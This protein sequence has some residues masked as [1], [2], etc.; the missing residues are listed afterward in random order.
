M[1]RRTF[2]EAA[3]GLRS[4]ISKAT[5]GN[6][7]R[8]FV[9][10]LVTVVAASTIVG[11]AF[12][13]SNASAVSALKPVATKGSSTA[14][15]PRFT[16]AY[17]IYTPGELYGG[18][19]AVAVCYTCE[20]ANI[21]GTAPPSSSLDAGSGVNALT[22]DYSTTNGLFGSAPSLG[23][24]LSLTY[25]AQ[26]AQ[27]EVAAGG[28]SGEFGVG[29]SSNFDD[30]VT[31]QSG[32]YTTSTVTV[33]QVNGS[34]V[35]FNQ[36]TNGGGCPSGANPSAY[37]YTVS[38]SEDYWC[39]LASV[40]AQLGDWGGTA[41][42]IEYQ[43]NNGQN[44]ES[45]N[46]NGSLASEQTLAPG[47]GLSAA[48]V[49]YNVAPHGMTFEPPCPT[50]AY[51]CT[52][53]GSA[54]E[55]ATT[56]AYIVEALNSSG[57]VTTVYDPSGVTYG[58]TYDTHNNLKSVESYAN[59]TSP[60]TWYYVYT[61]AAASPN[62]S[63]L[64]EIYDPNSGAT[65][66]TG[67]SS[68]AAHSN[69]IVYNTSGSDSGM[70]S[71]VTDGT[72]AT[73]SYSYADPCATGQCVATNAAQQTTVTYPTQVPCPSCTA[74]SPVEVDSYV[75]G[76]E[77]ST[78][79]GSSS[80]A[81]D[82]ETWSYNWSMG[83][84]AA[85]STETITYPNSLAGGTAPTASI[86]LDPEQNVISTTNALGDVATSAYDDVSGDIANQ[87]VWS[88]PGA[89][90][91]GYN[92][93]PAGSWVYTYNGNNEVIR[94]TDPLGNMTSYGYYT[95]DHDPCFV[96]QPTVSMHGKTNSCGAYG[97]YGPPGYAPTGSTAYTYDSFGNVVSTAVDFSDTA[98]GADP[99]TTT[100]SYNV[101]GD[102]L[103]S[104]P[105]AGQSG[106]QSS[107]NPYATVTTYTPSN[108]P[109]T[110][111]PPGHSATTNTY[112]AALN[113]ISSVS[114][115]AT[116]TNAYDADNRQ[117]YQV[118]GGS[119]PGLTC[120]TIS[121]TGTSAVLA[122]STATT[123]VPGSTTAFTSTDGK[124][125]TTVSYY[126]DLAYPSS[127]T[128]VVDAAG[129]QKQYTAYNDFGNAC[130][131]G[132]VSLASQQ[133]T[134]TQC[135]SVA[136]DT[137]TVYNA[138]GDE[139]SI[140]D[141][142]GNTTTNA[143]TNT[144]YP[145][146]ETSS[147]NALSKTTSYAYDADGNETKTTNPDGTFIYTAYDQ[148]NRICTR[149]DGATSDGCGVGTGSTGVTNY[150]YNGASDLTAM[151]AASLS[152]VSK[153]TV[154]GDACSLNSG[155]SGTVDCWGDL[156]NGAIGSSQIPL[157]VAG[158]SGV[159]QVSTG[160]NHTCALLSGG[161]V[162]CWGDN[163]YGELG[164][165]TTTS[166]TTPVTVTGLSNV[167]QVSAGST[168]TCAV[169]T[170]H[171][172]D[173]W[174]DNS[175]Y[176]AGLL[177]NVS[178]LTPTAVPGV[179]AAVS[180]ST[181]EDHTCVDLTGGGAQC[182]GQ[183]G[184]YQLGDENNVSHEP[185]VTVVLTG[186]SKISVGADF[187]CAL[188]T[189]GTVDCWGYEPAIG[190]VNVPTSIT[191]LSGVTQIINDGEASC[192]LLSAGTVDCWGWGAQG[193]LGNGAGSNSSTPVAVSNLTGV[194]QI[195]GGWESNC[196][197]LTG[198]TVD[199]WGAGAFGDPASPT[200]ALSPVPVVTSASYSYANGQLVNTTDPNGQTI[201]Y[202][203][204]Y[205]GQVACTAY[206]IVSTSSCGTIS[207][208]A[209]A[210]PTNT[211][212]KRTYDTAG[213]LSSIS[214]WMT[215]NNTVNYTYGDTNFPYSPTV[216]T[217]PSSLNATYGYDS[218][219]NPTSLEV[220]SGSAINDTWTYNADEQVATTKING[221]T[222]A[223]VTYN[224]NSQI[225]G[226]ANLATSTSNDTYSVA[227]NGE[228]TSDAPPSGS[229][230]DFTYNA[231]DE[232]CN[233][234]S[235]SVACGTN[236]STGTNY[237]FTTNG[238]RSVTT[239]Y[240]GGIAGAATYDAWNAYGELCNVATSVTPCGST[241]SSG[242][243]YQYNGDGLRLSATTSTTSTA[244]AWDVVSGGSIP[245]NVNDAATT[246]GTT[247]NTSYLYG[248]LLFGGTAPVEQISGS[249]ATFLVASPTGVQGVYS[250]SGAVNELAIYSV[251]GKQT[252]SSGSKVTPF[253][254]QGSYTD[255]TGLIYLIN[256]Y[257]DPTTDQFL[258]I[259]PNVAT[260]NQPYVFT[261][262]NPLNVTDPLGLSGNGGV[263]V[264]GKPPKNL[265][266]V[267]VV[268]L[269]GNFGG[270]LS[271]VGG[272]KV[273]VEIHDNGNG[274]GWGPYE[275]GPQTVSLK[276]PGIWNSSRGFSKA[277]DAAY[278]D[279]SSATATG[280]VI[281]P[282]NGSKSTVR[283]KMVLS[284]SLSVIVNSV[285]VSD[286]V[287]VYSKTPVKVSW[288]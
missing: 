86:T 168:Y 77:S 114:S 36:S 41:G 15:R 124:G 8:V 17:P 149:S 262:D 229:A 211:I 71:S 195:A 278:F 58:M 126:A 52:D 250:S 129:L 99:Q 177:N 209:T 110:V 1:T 180:V 46:W 246:S 258:S 146:L 163:S 233:A 172:V 76:V 271:I 48:S 244:S 287:I 57:Q 117:C 284:Y 173:C 155:T 190:Y 157:A 227:A 39:A 202:V 193:E 34:Q 204:N 60:S 158:L 179:T 161:T 25:D 132:D 89:S 115:A 3:H 143:F 44:H 160:V 104:I 213:R 283:T 32:A 221:S 162:K 122:G 83:Y 197:L 260:T 29:W 255:S 151:T 232:L 251:Y 237:T 239:P 10:L 181:G 165:G 280:M 253:G 67:F 281:L 37:Y 131:S 189:G 127:P 267:E 45:F 75:G 214:D 100:A 264:T 24:S 242:T 218:D 277:G 178:Y 54:G 90:S 22:G 183:D 276:S 252:I 23:L 263:K 66:S 241:P 212:E 2:H 11:G 79:L 156:G 139:T 210:S 188:L 286:T 108:L 141:A 248:N 12:V 85:N 245:L 26:L 198:G 62:G 152:G 235:S 192:A 5:P 174:G 49:F 105:P 93:P 275:P 53:I 154:S 145:T 74:V 120:P 103:W 43:T 95:S 230:T 166:S 175:L 184:S 147:E 80:N 9:P 59:Q 225:T 68:G 182:W 238:Q 56:P 6:P 118:V 194:T 273:V 116:T 7:Q 27:A 187:T 199:C 14:I 137:M 16:T 101:M 228:I 111:T 270:K 97:T 130:V 266:S 96:A 207:S 217:Y 102:Q 4:R 215:T 107:S 185:P 205:D 112:D 243:S 78:S 84:G 256:R 138:L 98:V 42:E 38:S 133:G 279:L 285:S 19:N 219:G 171:A 169:L 21:T 55:G 153:I 226:A 136:G 191:G 223:T 125:N 236:P 288:K 88:Y 134:S 186:I 73:T 70:V 220:G 31:P 257:Y 224:A 282:V 92:N 144:A 196:A 40:Q 203:Y 170:T 164:N 91:N 69:A 216:I 206:P 20:A 47:R 142:S 135:S 123:Y 269:A 200:N 113:L 274:Q 148:N 231:G 249:T 18:S 13:A 140:T 109:L 208:P 33:N 87:L 167:T 222:S 159:T 254:F 247:T 106:S 50:T 150:V 81:Y 121:L 28:T 261:N 265:G 65:S 128:E 176:Q 51:E 82:K 259:D 201:S 30:S 272:S 94:A 234:A 64:E 35:T 268:I 63:D 240:T 72:G 61:T 119:E